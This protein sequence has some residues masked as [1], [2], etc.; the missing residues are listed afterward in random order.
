MNKLFEAAQIL[1]WENE[2]FDIINQDYALGNIDAGEALDQT[3]AVVTL[4]TMRYKQALATPIQ[5][6]MYQAMVNN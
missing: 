5:D 6:N 1:K 2:Q 4:T 3:A